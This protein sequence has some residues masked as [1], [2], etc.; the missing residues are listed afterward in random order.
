MLLPRIHRNRFASFRQNREEIPEEPGD[1]WKRLIVLLIV[2]AIIFFVAGGI[3]LMTGGK[4]K[5]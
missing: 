2:F 1:L 4:V 3:F 5:W